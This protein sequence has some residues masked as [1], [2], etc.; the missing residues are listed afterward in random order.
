MAGNCHFAFAVH[1]LSVL[2]LHSE[3]AISSEA[4]AHSVNT[5]AVVI[6]RLLTDLSK[7]GLIAT[8]R[9]PGG[10]SRLARPASEITL[11]QVHRAVAGEIHA[12]G[13][14]PNQPAQCCPVGHG[15][16]RVLEDVRSRASQAV[17]NEYSKLTLADVVLAVNMPQKS[18]AKAGL[19]E[20]R[21]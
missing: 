11:L 4:L 6:R 20:P 9:G 10:G 1:V 5:N 17:E 15:I 14:H 3:E 21:A 18:C 16:Q 2:A 19:N 12:F 7:S 8:Q 13:E